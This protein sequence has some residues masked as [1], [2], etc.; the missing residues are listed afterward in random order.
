MLGLF[1]FKS[2]LPGGAAKWGKH[3]L[4]V[5]FWQ[6]CVPA[7]WSPPCLTPSPGIPC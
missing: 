5:A 1:F 4:P 3:R 7:A 2:Q 6:N